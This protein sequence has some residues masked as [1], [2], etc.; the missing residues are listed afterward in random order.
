MKGDAAEGASWKNI[1]C[2]DILEVKELEMQG[3]A[4]A[5]DKRG[6]INEIKD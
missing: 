5:R 4:Q 3:C 2:R 1:L 6:D